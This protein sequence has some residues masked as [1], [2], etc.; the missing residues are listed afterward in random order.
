[1]TKT[2]LLYQKLK[3]LTN[4]V[5][6]I[7]TLVRLLSR[8]MKTTKS[9]FGKLHAYLAEACCRSCVTWKN[10]HAPSLK[11]FEYSEGMMCRQEDELKMQCQLKVEYAQLTMFQ[12]L[13]H[14]HRVRGDGRG[15]SCE[16]GRRCGGQYDGK[17]YDP[18]VCFTCGQKIANR[19]G[20]ELDGMWL[21][22]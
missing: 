5:D 17:L 9:L 22:T 1:M 3:A 8:P 15:R 19:N 18:E 11:N 2:V 14:S 20:V 21:L 7:L 13:T 10:L 6:L 12:A 4:T 16:Y